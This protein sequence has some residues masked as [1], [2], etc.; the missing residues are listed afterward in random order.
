MKVICTLVLSGLPDAQVP[1]SAFQVYLEN[2]AVKSIQA[3]APSLAHSEQIAD[4]AAGDIVLTAGDGEQAIEFA[5]QAITGLRID[6][7]AHNQSI[8]IR[9]AA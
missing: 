8:T 2:G 3:V 7:G 1:I 6:N 4:R 9:S 5:R